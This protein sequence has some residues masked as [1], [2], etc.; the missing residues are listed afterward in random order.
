MFGVI[1]TFIWRS[2]FTLTKKKLKVVSYK[3]TKPSGSTHYR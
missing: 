2:K 1:L 3:E